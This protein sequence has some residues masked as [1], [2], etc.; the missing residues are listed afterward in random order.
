MQD[1]IYLFCD[2]GTYGRF[3][4]YIVRVSTIYTGMYGTMHGITIDYRVEFQLSTLECM[5]QCMG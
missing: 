2:H 5:V 1:K 3:M 4:Y